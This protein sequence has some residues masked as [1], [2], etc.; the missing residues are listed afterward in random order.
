MAPQLLVMGKQSSGVCLVADSSTGQLYWAEEDCIV[1]FKDI[2]E[3]V[4][5]VYCHTS[6]Y[7][8]KMESVTRAQLFQ[9]M[10][11]G[12]RYCNIVGVYHEHLSA[13]LVG[14]PDREMME[15]LPKSCKWFAH[16][17]AGY[18]SVDVAAAKE[19]GK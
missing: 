7:S 17:G 3:V 16:K 9:D 4:V 8:Q 1:L 11:P 15:A 13:E 5:S 14:Q 6:A 12:G 2:A 10:K 19:K 18:D